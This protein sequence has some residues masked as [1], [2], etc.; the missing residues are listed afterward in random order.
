MKKLFRSFQLLSI[1]GFNSCSQLLKV[2][3]NSSKRKIQN[4]QY[5]LYLMH[6]EFYAK[7]IEGNWKDFNCHQLALELVA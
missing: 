2:S 4:C 7:P 1:F 6:S 3:F 5:Y